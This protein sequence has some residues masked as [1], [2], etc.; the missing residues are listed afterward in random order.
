MEKGNKKICMAWYR[1]NYYTLNHKL[2]DNW[3]WYFWVDFGRNCSK[4]FNEGGGWCVTSETNFEISV[5][6]TMLYTCMCK[7]GHKHESWVMT[8][9][10][11][12]IILKKQRTKIC[13]ALYESG[14]S[15]QMGISINVTLGS[16]TLLLS[17]ER[18]KLSWHKSQFQPQS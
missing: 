6:L 3:E 16:S 5:S 7:T 1:G 4:K 13:L 17:Q 18:G 10:P 9:T 14:T 12:L 11:W 2:Q 15:C 8:L